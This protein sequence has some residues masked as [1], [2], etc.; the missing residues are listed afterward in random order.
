MP[1]ARKTPPPADSAS[2]DAE[3]SVGV[4]R[5]HPL[6]LALVASAL[7]AWLA[8]LAYLAFRG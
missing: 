6:L 7:V 4:R 5:K 2:A 8:F 1:R 3:P